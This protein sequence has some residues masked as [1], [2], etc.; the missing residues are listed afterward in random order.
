M[1]MITVIQ[2]KKTGKKDKFFTQQY[3]CGLYVAVYH[4]GIPTPDQFGDKR[5]EKEFH[6]QLRKAL[7]KREATLITEE[8]TVL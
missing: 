5:S 2:A 6:E 8:S 7:N 4:Q 3:A 1:S